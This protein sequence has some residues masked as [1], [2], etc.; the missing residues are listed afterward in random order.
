M[1]A[2][3]DPLANLDPESRAVADA[4]AEYGAFTVD[5]IGPAALRH[6]HERPHRHPHDR[7]LTA[8]DHR[9]DAG[10]HAEPGADYAADADE[11]AERVRRASAHAWAVHHAE[12]DDEPVA[13]A[14]EHGDIDALRAA[15]DDACARR[16]HDDVAA[17]ARRLAVHPDVHR[18]R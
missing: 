8:G 2:Q 6:P 17:L 9:P 1:D 3:P 4:L 12:S 16:D 18:P 13:D 14:G 11:L 10:T 5:N 7:A 15:Y